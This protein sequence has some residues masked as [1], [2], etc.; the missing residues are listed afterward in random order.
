MIP[1]YGLPF[2]LGGAKTPRNRRE[3]STDNAS[4][5]FLLFPRVR[6][7]REG[8]HEF[9]C[10]LLPRRS[11]LHRP[12]GLRARRSAASLSQPRSI[13]VSCRCRMRAPRGLR[14]LRGMRLAP[15]ILR[16][17]LSLC[18]GVLV[19]PRT[20]SATGGLLF[21]RPVP[22]GLR[23]R[24]L[25][26]RLRALR[27]RPRLLRG[28][29]LRPDRRPV[30]RRALPRGCGLRRRGLLQPGDEDLCPQGRLRTLRQRRAA[31]LPSH[32]GALR[33]RG[34]RLRRR[35]RRGFSGL[36]PSLLGGRGALLAGRQPGLRRGRRRHDLRRPAGGPC[37][38][39]LRRCGQ[40]LRWRDR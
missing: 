3:A 29:P 25:S 36:G 21:Q 38:R 37:A 34:E 14:P 23:V 5:G 19:L 27:L 28:P 30:S 12:L 31:R 17:R 35:H 32:A 22:G 16:R 4:A 8:L 1:G 11:Y 18:G 15:S 2:R 20:L 26:L 33:R 39:G 40:R 13:P 24:G 10:P 7:F 6:K 9:L